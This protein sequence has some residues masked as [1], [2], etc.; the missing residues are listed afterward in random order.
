MSYNET[1][2]D[3]YQWIDAVNKVLGNSGEAKRRYQRTSND[4]SDVEYYHGGLQ[5]K[6]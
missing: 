3:D 5:M 4:H 2:Q 1:S 6:N